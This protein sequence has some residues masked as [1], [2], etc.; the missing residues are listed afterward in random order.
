M[1]RPSVYLAGPMVFLPDPVAIFDQMKAICDA[2]ALVGLAPLDNQIGLE[3]LPP[4]PDLLARIVR[5]DIELMHSVD[6][7]VFCLDGFRR[8]PEMDAG[9]AFEVGFMKA[10]GKPLAGWTAD[11][12]P[13]P[14]KVK[15]YF[16]EVFG[17]PLSEARPGAT[18]GT[19]G[20]TRDP[21]GMLVH[22]AGCLQNGMVHI[23]IELSGGMVAAD[24]D[25]KRAFST[26]VARLAEMLGGQHAT[27]KT[28]NPERPAAPARAHGR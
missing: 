3:G 11:P 7:G 25:W 19:S 24:P 6:A 2:H 17:L 18:G 16:S 15:D 13:Y 27:G 5:A 26:A 21:D 23:G 10:L 1:T 14:V 4:G 28:N 22:S 12:R 20:L 9:T 8:G